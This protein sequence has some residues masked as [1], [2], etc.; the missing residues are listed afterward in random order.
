MVASP[1]SGNI[2][3]E[4]DED[5]QSTFVFPLAVL[6]A[7]CL[8]IVDN[9][10]WEVNNVL[11]DIEYF[12]KPFVML[13]TMLHDKQSRRRFIKY[14]VIDS[15]FARYQH[16]IKGVPTTA[17][18]RWGVIVRILHKMLPIMW[19]L[20]ATF[21]ARKYMMDGQIDEGGRGGR[22]GDDVNPKHFDPHVVERALQ[23]NEWE[24]YCVVLYKSHGA[25]GAWGGWT[26][27]C[28][29]HGFLSQLDDEQKNALRHWR[30]AC[31]LTE[32][33]G[34]D[35]TCPMAGLRAPEMAAGEWRQVFETIYGQHELALL[36]DMPNSPQEASGR[37]LQRFRKQQN[38]D[39]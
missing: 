16:L 19:L 5:D 13:V 38:I 30:R 17:H 24:A 36:R 35:F 18:W 37:T 6:I 1:T 39:S 26:Q 8:H 25:V 14:C 10:A 23:D 12:L 3:L 29:C 11:E 32:G 28:P 21:S 4:D 9:L 20:R 34:L 27:A 22:T 15:E 33:D 31:N 7:E 2:D